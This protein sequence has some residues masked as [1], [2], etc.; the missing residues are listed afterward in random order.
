MANDKPVKV[1]VSSFQ[2]NSCSAETGFVLQLLC[3][4]F[5]SH[6]N[7]LI[8]IKLITLNCQISRVDNSY[9]FQNFHWPILSN[10]LLLSIQHTEEIDGRSNRVPFTLIGFNDCSN[11][12]VAVSSR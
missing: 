12:F 11:Q 10:S 4:R 8:Q 9:Y 7:T 2:F 1:D 5:R 3:M 6:P